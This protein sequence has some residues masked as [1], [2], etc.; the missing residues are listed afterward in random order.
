MLLTGLRT[1]EILSLRYEDLDVSSKSVFLSKT[2]AGSRRTVPI[3][4]SVMELLQS[5]PRVAGN[6]YLFP[7]RKPGK[8]LCVIRKAFDRVC[9]EAGITKR[10]VPHQLRH[11]FASHGLAVHG[12]LEELQSLLGHTQ[13][14][15]TGRYAHLA[16][17]ATRAVANRIAARLTGPAIPPT[18]PTNPRSFKNEGQN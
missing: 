7:G 6:P 11:T 10:L 14:A 17:S 1:G 15:T 9:E 4:A 18:K 2:K 3:A 8:P 12:S 16:P 13:G 5:L